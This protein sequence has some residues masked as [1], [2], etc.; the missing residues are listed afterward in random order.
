MYAAVGVRKASYVAY[1][2]EIVGRVVM[3]SVWREQSWGADF[4]L[5]DDATWGSVE[6]CRISM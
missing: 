2:L 4:V 5:I 3:A 6:V 1:L